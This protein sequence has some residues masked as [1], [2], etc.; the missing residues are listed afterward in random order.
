MEITNDKTNIDN[1]VKYTEMVY[2]LSLKP[3]EIIMIL[4]LLG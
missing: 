4:F 3:G 1:C 2:N